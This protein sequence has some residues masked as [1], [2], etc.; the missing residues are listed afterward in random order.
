LT[1]DY[2]NVSEPVY[3]FSDM[4]APAMLKLNDYYFMFA[5]HLT[6]W[7]ANDNEYSYAT[8]LSGPWSSWQTF[9]TVGSDTYESQT[10]YILPFPGNNTIMYM[11]DRWVST[12]LFAST[13]V[14]LP[15]TFDGTNVTM[16]DY[17]SWVPDVQAGTW[18]TAPAETENY[19]VNAALSNGA[20][21]VSCTGCY[22]NE[23]AGYIGG[24][25]GGIAT[26][27]DVAANVSGLTTVQIMYRNGDSTARYANVT[28]ND[29]VAQEIEFLPSN[30]PGT[31]VLF[32]DLEA[33]S[34]NVVIITTTDGTYGPDI[35]MLV[36]PEQ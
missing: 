1:D 16:Q 29:G 15:L 9:A 25:S 17:G 5:S 11:G 36:V 21:I 27:S 28:V 13:Y 18:S 12:N 8:S 20:V 6:G 30:S 19:G 2:L 10:N 23:A 24:P 32:C 26:F 31:S 7:D 14:W 33:K 3:L 35:D 34:D 22:D 4:E